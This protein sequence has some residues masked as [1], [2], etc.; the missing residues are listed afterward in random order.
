LSPEQRRY[1]ILQ[2]GF[3]AAIANAIL[4]G[5]IGWVITRGLTEFPVWGIPGVFTDLVATAF[6]VTF[7]T[8]IAVAIQVPRDVAKNK[9]SLPSLSPSLTAALTRLPQGVWR[10]AI[11]LGLLA[12]LVC[13]PA[14]VVLLAATGRQALEPRTFIAIKAVLSAI[15]GGLITPIAVLGVLFNTA[16]AE[17]AK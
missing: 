2:S 7:G 14:L 6:G 3:G 1:L 15:E 13:T 5:V 12:T 9:I 17:P 10:R 16:R 8:F 11:W 4:N